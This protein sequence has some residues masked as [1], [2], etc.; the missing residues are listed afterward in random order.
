VHLCY[1]LCQSRNAELAAAA[2]VPFSCSVGCHLSCWCAEL[3]A[4]AKGPAGYSMLPRVHSG[5]PYRLVLLAVAVI[6][7]AGYLAC[8]PSAAMHTRKFHGGRVARASRRISSI[9]RAAQAAERGVQERV[10]AGSSWGGGR[11]RWQAGWLT[12][13]LCLVTGTVL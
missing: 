12:D 6:V 1:G 8:C 9:T 11:V 5:V 2:C 10:G 13:C 3:Q 7:K 4:I